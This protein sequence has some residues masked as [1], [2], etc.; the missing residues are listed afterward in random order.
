MS[1]RIHELG[2]TARDGLS[3]EM[4]DRMNAFLH[5]PGTREVSAQPVLLPA[6]EVLRLWETRLRNTG[7]TGRPL[8]G[9]A[10]LVDRLRDVPATTEIQQVGLV[11]D[12]MRMAGN[13]F[14]ASDAAAGG[15]RIVGAV[16]VT[17]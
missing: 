16:I 17:A 13:L 12:R 9:A 4:V 14:L 2:A 8:P 11:N 15:Q 1:M 6:S 7:I 3:Q 5:D 10:G